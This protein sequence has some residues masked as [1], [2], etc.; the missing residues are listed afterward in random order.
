V[1]VDYRAPQVLGDPGNTTT[2]S[3]LIQMYGIVPN[4]TVGDVMNTQG[5]LLCY[6]YD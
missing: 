6:E 4:Q 3:H 1:Y 2:L 5:T